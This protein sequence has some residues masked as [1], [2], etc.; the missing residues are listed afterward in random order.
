MAQRLG[1]PLIEGDEFHSET[2]RARM[3]SGI[4]LTD[5]DRAGWL[6]GLGPQPQSRSGQARRRLR[7]SMPEH[8]P[9]RP[10]RASS[11]WTSQAQ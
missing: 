4:A 1:L 3:K 2:N 6:A 11:R 8:P 5:A 7:T 9:R 10:P